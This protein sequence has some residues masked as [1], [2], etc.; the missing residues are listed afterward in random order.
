MIKV[1][2][3][4]FTSWN[5]VYCNIETNITINLTRFIKINYRKLQKIKISTNLSK[6][7]L[8]HDMLK[9]FEK[10]I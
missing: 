5:T 10:D 7:V 4:F 1:I 6:I 2:W 8:L 3:L 9:Q